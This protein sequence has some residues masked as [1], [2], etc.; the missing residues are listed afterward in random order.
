MLQY[1]IRKIQLNHKGLETN[2]VNHIEVHAGMN[3]NNVKNFFENPLHKMVLKA[4]YKNY[5][6]IQEKNF[7]INIMTSVTHYSIWR[8]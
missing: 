8:K 1:I 3:T 5:N 4:R 2:V 7:I 6:L